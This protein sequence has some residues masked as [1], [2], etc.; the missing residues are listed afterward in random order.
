MC[1]FSCQYY[2]PLRCKEITSSLLA[3]REIKPRALAFAFPLF[4][5]ENTDSVYL[6]FC[7]AV[8]RYGLQTLARF[9]FYG[10]S[11]Y[12]TVEFTLK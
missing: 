4:L 3:T 11:I 10:L 6:P 9:S 5:G 7:R 8:Q 2:V 12:S 1:R